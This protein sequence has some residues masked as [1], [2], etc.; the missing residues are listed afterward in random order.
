ML[1]FN[2]V[3]KFVAI[4]SPLYTFELVPISLSLEF[5]LRFGGNVIFLYCVPYREMINCSHKCPLNVFTKHFPHK[6]KVSHKHHK[7][8]FFLGWEGYVDLRP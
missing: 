5:R 7:Q 6:V 8:K 2:L 4:T 3:L 1:I